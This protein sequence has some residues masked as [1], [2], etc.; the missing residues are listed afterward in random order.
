TASSPAIAWA[1]AGGAEA[2][3]CTARRLR[4]SP[5]LRATSRNVALLAARSWCSVAARFAV[6]WG[7]IVRSMPGM[8]VS[9][10]VAPARCTGRVQRK[11]SR[12]RSLHGVHHALHAP[13]EERE[14]LLV[15]HRNALLH[16]QLALLDA[17]LERP[18]PVSGRDAPELVAESKRDP[19]HVVVPV[20]PL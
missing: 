8:V 15:G 18:Y 1:T 16:D 13:G 7:R 14:L 17:A 9:P 19:N 12:L 20:D 10:W 2:A 4:C 3:A 11:L 6:S 5:M